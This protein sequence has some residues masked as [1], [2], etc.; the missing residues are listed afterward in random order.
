MWGAFVWGVCV[1]LK[2]NFFFFLIAKSKAPENY[3]FG[4]IMLVLSDY[5]AF[6]IT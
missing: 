2:Q 4:Y 1:C 5:P 3:K 6:V